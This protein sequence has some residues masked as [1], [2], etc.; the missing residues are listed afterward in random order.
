LKRQ[1]K[2]LSTWALRLNLRSAGW[3]T[4]DGQLQVILSGEGLPTTDFD[5]FGV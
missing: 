2:G 3:S 5:H 1:P 4:D